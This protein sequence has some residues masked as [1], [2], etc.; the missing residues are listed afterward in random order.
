[1][2][3]ERPLDIAERALAIAAQ[4]GAEIQVTVVRERSLMSRYARSAPTQAT[5]VDD[6]TVEILCLC[7]GHTAIASTNR[8]DD[9]ALRDTAARAAAAARAV[10]ASGPGTHPGLARP[11]T[12]L[13][14]DGFDE[15]TA[16]LDPQLAAT[17]LAAAFAVA[18]EH[19]LEAFGVWTAGDV[20]TAIAST[21][22][23]RLDDRVSDSF[24][25]VVCRDRDGRSG[26]AVDAAVAATAIDPEAVAWRAAAKVSPEPL[27]ELGPGSYP[28]V[29]EPEAVGQLLEFL[30]DLA[31]NGL[32]HAE[33]RGALVGRIGTPVAAPAVDLRDDPRAPRTLL[34]SFDMEG[35]PKTPV[36]LIEDGVATG[37]V[38]DLRSA[39]VAGDGA[40]STGHALQTGGSP[41]GAVPTNL[42]LRGGDAA[43]AAELAAPIERGIY[44]TRLWYVNAVREK[45]TLLTGMTR[46]GTFL[47]EDGRIARPL[48]DVRFTDSVLRL[49]DATEALTSEQ[50]LVTEGE[51][52]G[53]RFAHGVVC[54]AL[55]AGGFRVTGATTGD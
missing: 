32:A 16:Q 38:H 25:K 9:D 3:G 8:L 43:D 12:P 11:A 34:R 14:H 7:D 13:P 33:G 47:I 22:G 55:R 1:M 5:S 46:D 48:R 10:A 37:V 27:A 24:M 51:F 2:S 49:L 54:P 26:Y 21:T 29:L 28:V 39:A 42:V 19:G 45:E 17:A 18:A 6:T 44:V 15:Q 31:H 30:G 4:A 50:R 52:Y 35:V 36:A 53:R 41:W 20:R 23:L 40:R